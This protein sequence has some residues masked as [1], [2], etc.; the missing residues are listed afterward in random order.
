MKFKTGYINLKKYFWLKHT[1]VFKYCMVIFK[2][3]LKLITIQYNTH[4]TQIFIIHPFDIL[5]NY[6]SLCYIVLI[7]GICHL[8]ARRTHHSRDTRFSP[9]L[10]SYMCATNTIKKKRKPPTYMMLYEK[11]ASQLMHELINNCVGP[12]SICYPQ[13][14]RP[15]VGLNKIFIQIKKNTAMVIVRI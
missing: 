8:N 12:Y 5:L 4:T 2:P 1:V 11:F 6:F 14:H 3:I 15:I 10:T 9:Q 7:P 13:E